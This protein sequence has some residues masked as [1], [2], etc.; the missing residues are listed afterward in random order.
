MVIAL[1]IVLAIALFVV[2]SRWA[3][4][5]VLIGGYALV[6]MLFRFG[7]GWRWARILRF[8]EPD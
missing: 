1:A 2:R 7:L 5:V 4:F 3:G 8:R 6:F